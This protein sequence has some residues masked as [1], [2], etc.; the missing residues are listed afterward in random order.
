MKFV[1]M[2][3]A[4]VHAP[5]K[6][7]RASSLFIDLLTNSELMWR[8][9]TKKENIHVLI[10]SHLVR[11]DLGSHPLGV[12]ACVVRDERAC[13]TALLGTGSSVCRPL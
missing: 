8:R 9:N 4:V 5:G 3:T 11:T 6:C 7:L 10:G 1:A 2:V 13:K 12:A